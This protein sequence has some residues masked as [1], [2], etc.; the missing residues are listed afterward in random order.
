MLK[1]SNLFYKI[2][3]YFFIQHIFEYLLCVKGYF[4]LW[5]YSN[6]HAYFKKNDCENKNIFKN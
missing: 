1:K 3:I 2:F 4:R 5:E 6:E